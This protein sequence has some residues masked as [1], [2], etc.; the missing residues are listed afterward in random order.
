M[1][2]KLFHRIIIIRF[3]CCLFGERYAAMSR[4]EYCVFELNSNYNSILF[5]FVRYIYKPC[6]FAWFAWL[7]WIGGTLG[8]HVTHITHM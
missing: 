2:R 5:C 6:S 1:I 7:G 3:V 8:A 4:P